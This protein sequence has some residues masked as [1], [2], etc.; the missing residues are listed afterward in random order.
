M[1]NKLI[2]SIAGIALGAISGIALAAMGGGSQALTADEGCCGGCD[3]GCVCCDGGPC[4]CEDC[5]CDAGGCCEAGEAPAAPEPAHTCPEG[6]VCPV[7]S[8]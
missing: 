8:E 5:C 1:S 4:N 2:A 6:L 7:C 3:A